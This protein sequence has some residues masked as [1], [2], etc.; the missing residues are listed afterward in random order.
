[1]SEIN[2]TAYWQ[3]HNNKMVR[4]SQLEENDEEEEEKKK[5]KCDRYLSYRYHLP[6]LFVKTRIFVADNP[7]PDTSG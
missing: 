5:K 6:L 2:Q 4:C 3:P 1:M 7:T